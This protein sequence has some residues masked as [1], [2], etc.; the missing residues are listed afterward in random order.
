MQAPPGPTLAHADPVLLLGSCFSIE[1]GERLSSAG[2]NAMCNPLGTIFNPDSLATTLKRLSSG[3][4][5]T[6]DDLLWCER[7]RHFF[8]WEVGTSLV[9]PE[10][11]GAVDAINARL[12][13]GSAQLQRS[14]CLFLT[15]GSAW[16]YALPD[17]RIVANCHRQP[18]TTF[19]RRLL[20]VPEATTAVLSAV[21]AARRANPSLRVVLTVSPV[22]HWREGAVESSRSKAHLIAA[23]HAAVE[24]LEDTFYFPAFE[25]LMD[26]L[27]DYRWYAEDLLHP[28]RQAADFVFKRLLESHFDEADAPLRAA[29][30]QLRGAAAH[31]PQRPHSEA[32]ARFAAQQLSRAEELLREHPHLQLDAELAHFGG[33]ATTASTSASDE[34][35]GQD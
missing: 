35:G 22:R 32:A 16:A 2:H 34:C 25:L 18:H 33:G 28:S 17:G 1:M 14:R 20:T 19:S 9:H 26:E 11:D 30:L 8:H 12:A 10:R 15:L 21:G 7:Q 13:A 4:L 27:R 6:P 23:A 31:R 3:A 5:V 24:Q 29:V